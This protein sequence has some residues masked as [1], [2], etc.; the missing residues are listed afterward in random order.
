[1]FWEHASE[2]LASDPAST[3]DL[4]RS[5]LQ[6]AVPDREV[7]KAPV[8]LTPIMAVKSQIYIG[9]YRGATPPSL[10]PPCNSM[11]YIDVASGPNSSSHPELESSITQPILHLTLPPGKRGQAIFLHDILPLSIAFAQRHL[12]KTEDPS[13]LAI[14]CSDGTDISVGVGIAIMQ[15]LFDEQG[16]L[17]EAPLSLS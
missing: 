9:R 4:V 5:L 3:H 1:V 17:S 11:I 2:L 7:P 6:P 8:G 14:V 12:R 10:P 16:N 13:A 15:V